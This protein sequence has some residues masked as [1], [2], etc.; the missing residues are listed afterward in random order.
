MNHLAEDT[1]RLRVY[2]DNTDC[3]A[4]AVL[5]GLRGLGSQGQPPTQGSW[6]KVMISSLVA[7]G[8]VY[9]TKPFSA[10]V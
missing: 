5:A 4:R 10:Q 8:T 3:D 1:G 9:L 7:P 6:V 2:C